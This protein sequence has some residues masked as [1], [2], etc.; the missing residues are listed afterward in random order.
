MV[1]VFAGC[2]GVMQ[3]DPELAKLIESLEQQAH[4]ETLGFEE[5]AVVREA[6]RAWDRYGRTRG[7]TLPSL[8]YGVT[9]T[10][11]SWARSGAGIGRQ[12]FRRHW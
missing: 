1:S 9:R 4:T 12:R 10:R 11:C 8:H 6:R 3:A 2:G 5:R 7:D